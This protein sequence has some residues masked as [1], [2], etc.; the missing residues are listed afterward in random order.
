M[1]P[2]NCE[3]KEGMW[4]EEDA[5]KELLQG[6]LNIGSR[7]LKEM[8]EETDVSTCTETELRKEIANI[9]EK[10][11]QISFNKDDGKGFYQITSFLI[12]ICFEIVER[13]PGVYCLEQM[14]SIP[15]D[16]FKY[17]G[18]HD[19]WFAKSYEGYPDDFA[20]EEEKEEDMYAHLT[21]D[22]GLCTKD[23]KNYYFLLDPKFDNE[24]PA[25]R[26]IRYIVDSI[27]RE[28]EDIPDEDFD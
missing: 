21:L 7:V 14:V 28:E 17:L 16:E 6:F 25:I 22:G 24:S 4:S 27:K 2:Y 18:K 1:A 3:V 11:V 13:E 26:K 10:P 5:K 20:H 19:I 12:P 23:E 9:I 15:I 8:Y